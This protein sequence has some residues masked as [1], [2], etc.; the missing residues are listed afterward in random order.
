MRGVRWIVIGLVAVA[1]SGCDLFLTTLDVSQFDPASV[2]PNPYDLAV[3]VPV[4]TMLAANAV[5]EAAIETVVRALDDAQRANGGTLLRSGVGNLDLRADGASP[6]DIRRI[7]DL[8]LFPELSEV[9]FRSNN[10][11]TPTWQTDLTPL[12]RLR[13]LQTLEL[14]SNGLETAALSDL[15]GDWPRLTSLELQG[16][17]GIG[18]IAQIER[19]VTAIAAAR[20]ADSAGQRVALDI[21]G[22]QALYATDPIAFGTSFAAIAPHLSQLRVRSMGIED[23]SW[24]PPNSPW[25]VLDISS[26]TGIGINGPAF[27]AAEFQQLGTNLPQLRVVSIEFLVPEIFP[28]VAANPNIVEIHAN[29][30][31]DSPVTPGFPGL[32]TSDLVGIAAGTQLEVLRIRGDSSFG[33]QVASFQPGWT[34]LWGYTGLRW[35]DISNISGVSSIAGISALQNLERLDISG[36]NGINTGFDEILN[37]PR[38]TYIN[39]T[40]VG[41]MGPAYTDTSPEI[42]AIINEFGTRA[43]IILPSGLTYTPPE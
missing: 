41:N 43:E 28:T 22:I 17:P 8:L 10:L 12:N 32:E 23:L 33:S 18:D 4:A 19:I 2:A 36:T 21:G 40:D 35:L 14:S 25:E 42:V 3:D 24:I 37:L 13:R 5:T 39:L 34:D 20:D 30:L 16:N 6:V 31:S 11:Y 29:E 26:N 7:D 38:L 15:L 1:L 9:R 27:D